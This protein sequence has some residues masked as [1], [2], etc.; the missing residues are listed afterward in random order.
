MKLNTINN[1]KPAGFQIQLPCHY[2]LLI[3][4]P[5]TACQNSNPVVF[6]NGHLRS[7]K[8]ELTPEQQGRLSTAL[9]DYHQNYNPE[10]RMLKEPFSSPGYHTTL[11]GGDVHRTRKSLR[12]AVA[13]MDTYNEADRQRA[14]GIIDTVLTFQVTNPDHQY[15]GI[16]PWFAEE[17]VDQMVPP[18]RNWADFC[19]TQLLEVILTHRDRI[20]EN[21]AERID[22]A[23]QNASVAIRRR[24]VG[25]G[26]TNIAIMGTFVTFAASELYRIDTLNQYA[27]QRMKNF[28]DFTLHHRG[29]TEFNSPTYTMVALD[30]L[31]R[32]RKY[33]IDP[34]MKP[35]IDSLYNIGWEIVATHFHQPTHQWSG[36]HSRCYSTL[37]RNSFYGNLYRATDGQLNFGSDEPEI[38]EHRIAHDLPDQY[39]HYFTRFSGH[40]VERDTFLMAENP[41][42]GTTYLTDQLSLASVNRTN[43]WNQRRPIL[44]YWSGTEN[45]NY[46]QVR[47]LHDLYDFS[48]GNVFSVQDQDEILSG[49]NFATNGGDTHTSLDRLDNGKFS[50]R[51]LRLRLEFHHLDLDD[52]QLPDSP[53]QPVTFSS[54]GLTFSFYS[55]V[56]QF[57]GSEPFWTKGEDVAEEEAWIDLVFYEG[58]EKAFD[59]SA[60]DQAAFGLAIKIHP[61]ESIDPETV[62]HKISEGKLE[63]N[64]NGKEI[65]I[66]MKPMKENE[67]LDNYTSNLAEIFNTI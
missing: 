50:A 26:Y 21:L 24:D 37:V 40:R 46:L 19:G 3:I 49:V 34:E 4:L 56:Q 27:R 15:F 16:W 65:S 66:P 41:I 45:T 2:L 62:K 1:Q 5:L 20:P 36:P 28:Y 47:F 44:G 8:I 38:T 10:A 39:L 31:S 25:P 42:L 9:E 55:P 17:S 18:D 7:T 52:V 51:D 23:I 57:D 59:L 29:F 67:L 13:L 11:K 33:I 53:E 58:E 63:L 64:W 14:I 61:T 48:A 22:Q 12:Y 6:D 32:M 60:M 43:F 54:D 35:M 30:E